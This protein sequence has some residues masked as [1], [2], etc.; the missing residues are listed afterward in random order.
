MEEVMEYESE[1]EPFQDSGSEYNPSEID[2][3]DDNMSS[4]S[5]DEAGEYE[6][7]EEDNQHFHA[8]GDNG[9]LPTSQWSP[10]QGN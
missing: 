1:E 5:S 3:I 4:N 7:S 8:G 10:Y 6:S 9:L 2:D